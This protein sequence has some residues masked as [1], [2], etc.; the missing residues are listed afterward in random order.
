M[1]RPRAL[2]SVVA[3]RTLRLERPRRRASLV[4]V[5]FGRPVRAPRPER[6]D[7]WWCPVQVSGLGRR[8][9]KKLAGE[10]SLQ[11]LILA[12]EFAGRVLPVEAERAGGHLT[13]LDDRESL[14]FANTFIS[15]LLARNLENCITGLADAVGV[16]ENGRAGRAGKPLARRLRA[17]I[18]SGGH[19]A[20]PRRIPPSNRP[21]ART[22]FAAGS[23]PIR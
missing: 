13:W 23:T 18:A 9:L 7:P 4:R 14:L 3:E 6:G 19:T 2:G 8:R 20:D 15:G 22:G 16:L 10:D 5:R 21:L 11:A 12:L 1:W 17:L